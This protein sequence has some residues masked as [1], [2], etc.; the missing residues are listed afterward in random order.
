M[1]CRWR[2]LKKHGLGAH[3]WGLKRQ[4]IQ[5]IDNDSFQITEEK[6]LLDTL[7]VF[8]AKVMER[9]VVEAVEIENTGV[10]EIVVPCSVM[11][12]TELFTFLE[13][14]HERLALLNKG[15]LLWREYFAKMSLQ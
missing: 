7:M 12:L 13:N 15:S 8:V 9:V 2:R 6:T 10:R 11:S 3:I 1:F 5:E 14:E 4:C